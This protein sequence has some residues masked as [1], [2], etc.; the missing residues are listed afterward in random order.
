MPSKKP[1]TYEQMSSELAELMA[2]FESESV[3][4]D[5]A[6]AKYEQSMKLLAEMETYL[7]TAKNKVNKIRASFGA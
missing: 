3:D 5:Q 1:K 4:L 7:K 6:L 2:W